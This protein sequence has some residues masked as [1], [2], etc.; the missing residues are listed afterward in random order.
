MMKSRNGYLFGFF[1]GIKM[2]MG[3]WGL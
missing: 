3:I 2:S 1:V